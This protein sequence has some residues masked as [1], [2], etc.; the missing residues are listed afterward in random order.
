MTFKQKI[1]C[2]FPNAIFEVEDHADGYGPSICP[3]TLGERETCP[4]SRELNTH[5]L[6]ELCN[7][8]WELDYSDEKK[9]LDSECV[10]LRKKVFELQGRIDR[11]T[12]ERGQIENVD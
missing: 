8:C 5:G 11:M 3:I 2:V 10:K 7:K 9:R 6:E 4:S 12:A 1:L